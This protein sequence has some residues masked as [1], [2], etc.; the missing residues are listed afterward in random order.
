MHEKAARDFSESIKF[1]PRL[2]STWVSRGKAWLQASNGRASAESDFRHALELE[3]ENVDAF[4]GLGELFLQGGDAAQAM[5]NFNRA[6]EANPALPASLVAR[7]QARLR[8]RDVDGAKADADDALRRGSRDPAAIVARGRARLSTGDIGG[9]QG[10][11]E[12]VVKKAPKYAPGYV[13]LGSVLRE[14][15]TPDKAIVE[16]NRAIA[17][18]PLLPE[19]W[20]HRGN[21][22]R[23]RGQLERAM[24]DLTNAIALDPSD[25]YLRLDR[26]VLFGNQGAWSQAQAEYHQGLALRPTRPDWFQQRLWHARTKSGE[27]AAAREEFASFVRSRPPSTPGRLAPKINDFLSG[28]L[29]EEEFLSLLERTEFSRIAIA[30]GYFFAGEKA[31]AEGRTA[32]A[33]ELLKRCLKTGALTSSGY[34]SAEIELRA[35]SR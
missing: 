6:V 33:A 19:A 2:A 27:A 5:T 15:G 23:D 3:P 31:L 1:K 9:A 34:S 13:G 20:Q 8:L 35:L 16:F 11:F 21:A 14:R 4:L 22:E 12:E 28:K 29:S 18:D 24:S 32:R 30:E 17:I 10:D 7:A 25:P 26:G